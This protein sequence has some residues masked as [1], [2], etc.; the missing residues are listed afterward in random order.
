LKPF[1]ERLHGEVGVG[2]S[3]VNGKLG[4]AVPDQLG[5]AELLER[6]QAAFAVN[7]VIVA[8]LADNLDRLQQPDGFDAF[9]EFG[10]RFV[11]KTPA[12][13]MRRR[14]DCCERQMNDSEVA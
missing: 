3:F 9:G 7:D 14:L 6:A 2:R 8:F 13:L 10:D 11:G 4:A 5:Y 1:S 12:R